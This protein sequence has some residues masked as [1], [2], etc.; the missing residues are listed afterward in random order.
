MSDG[1]FDER[2]LRRAFGR[3]ATG[4]CVI[5][6]AAEERPAGLTANS[7]STVSLRPPLVL[8]CLG[9][10]ASARAAFEASPYFAINV[11]RWD[12]QDLSRRFASPS[13]DRF[14]GVNWHAGLGGAPLLPDAIARFECRKAA[15]YAEG[16]HLVFIGAVERFAHTD[17]S[18]LLFAAGRYA[19]PASI[20]DFRPRD[21]IDEPMF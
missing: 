4:V 15:T 11:L 1:A 6:A 2:D 16:D 12:Q 9:A 10:A 3:F 14:A 7:F 18:P 8:W 13:P 17:D 5:T 20:P 21:T 19:M